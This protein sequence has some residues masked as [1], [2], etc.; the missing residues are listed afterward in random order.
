VQVNKGSRY[1]PVGHE[2]QVVAVSQVRHKGL[3][4]TTVEVPV[5]KKL[6]TG[7]EHIDIAPLG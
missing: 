1:V 4:G 3:Q 2:V 6:P 7:T 5:S